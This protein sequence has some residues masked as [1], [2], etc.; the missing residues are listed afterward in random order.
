MNRSGELLVQR[1]SPNKDSHPN[2]WD[3]SSAGHLTAGSNSIEGALREVS[4]ELGLEVEEKELEYLFSTKTQTVQ[5]NGT[6]INNEFHDVY[7]IVKDIGISELTLQ[8]EEVSEVKL[9]P[10]KELRKLIADKDAS[11]VRHDEEY[12]RLFE[13]LE[14]REVN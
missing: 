5:N 4:E 2:M 9:I 7:L 3:I 1:R 12:G 10:W 8:D 6:F 14:R 11:F 13:E